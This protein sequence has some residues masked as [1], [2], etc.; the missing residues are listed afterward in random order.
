MQRSFKQSCLFTLGLS[1]LFTSILFAQSKQPPAQRW[2]YK[3]VY[4]VSEADLDKLG[5]EGWELVA[6]AFNPGPNSLYYTLKRPKSADAPKYVEPAKR[7]APPPHTPACN[8]SLTQAP[9]IRGLRLGMSV[10]DLIELFPGANP[11]EFKGK[12]EQAKEEPSLGH[13]YFGFSGTQHKDRL[14]GQNFTV[15]LFDGKVTSFRVQYLF[16]NQTQ[17]GQIFDAEKFRDKLIEIFNLP[18]KAYWQES[19][20]NIN[21]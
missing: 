7:P 1:F 6:S 8:L 11:N 9:I 5:D 2:E 18:A 17:T 12:V 13:L 10:D 4:N 21:L 19:Q 16:A 15:N 14:E 3:T 20:G